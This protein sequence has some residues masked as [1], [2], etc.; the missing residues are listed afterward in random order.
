M[1]F[2]N[3]MDS[4][5]VQKPTLLTKVSD[6]IPQIICFI[7]TLLHRELAYATDDGSVYFDLNAYVKKYKY[8]KLKPYRITT[9]DSKNGKSSEDFA[10]WKAAKSDSE[11]SWMP[12]WGGKGRP[13][14]HVNMNYF[15]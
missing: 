12:S 3:D 10:L 13:G 5:S 1:A 6:F 2:L 11:P 4:L 9:V 15:S 8:G 14:W 7:E